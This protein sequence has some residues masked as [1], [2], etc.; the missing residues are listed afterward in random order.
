MKI[1]EADLDKLN[2]IKYEIN[3]IVSV[4]GQLNIRRDLIIESEEELK[5][6]FTNIDTRQLEI[7][8]E[9]ATD[10]ISSIQKSFTELVAFHNKMIDEK[11][12]FI[13]KEL[14][15]IQKSIKREKRSLKKI[16]GSREGTLK[17]NF[18]G[19]IIY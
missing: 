14:P 13:T 12:K 16:T 10:K 2:N 6:G 9:Q 1:L 15:N 11:L 4:V 3:K 18:K 5:S 8:Y 7:I 17:L 19:R